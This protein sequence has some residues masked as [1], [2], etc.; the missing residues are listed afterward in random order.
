MG[1]ITN[2]GVNSVAKV[3]RFRL[4]NSEPS[5]WNCQCGLKNGSL[6]IS[7]IY[8]KLIFFKNGVQKRPS[9]LDFWGFPQLSH[10]FYTPK[11]RWIFHISKKSQIKKKKCRAQIFEISTRPRR[12]TQKFFILSL[13]ELWIP[14][15][16]MSQHVV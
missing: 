16:V 15:H 4:P 3:S 2:S 14:C 8:P 7:E 11:D 13:T 6:N 1:K 10:I 12:A 9:C 5:C